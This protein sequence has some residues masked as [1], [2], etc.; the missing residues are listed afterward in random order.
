L[1]INFLELDVNRIPELRGGAA[2]VWRG[3]TGTFQAL[4]PSRPWKRI[5][6]K[7]ACVSASLITELFV[8]ELKQ[9][10]SFSNFF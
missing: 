2:A 3:K 1:T 10:I 7:G 5:G 4:A 9:I 6:V 8:C